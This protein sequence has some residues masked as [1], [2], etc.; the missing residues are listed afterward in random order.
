MSELVCNDAVFGEMS[1]KHRWYKKQKIE[2]FGQTWEIAVAAKAYTG[3]SIT[4]EQRQSYSLFTR[5]EREYVGIISEEIK[6]YVNAHR[7]ELAENWVGARMI[8][9]IDDIAQVA[10]PKT[11]LFK[12]DGT[13]IMLLDCVWD[14]ESGIGVKIIPEVMI[15]SQDVF[16]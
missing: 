15:G 1:Y 5:E 13:T 6:N 8:D 11:L 9:D 16:L 2:M 7:Q 12:Q 3:R 10:R 4:E 14:I